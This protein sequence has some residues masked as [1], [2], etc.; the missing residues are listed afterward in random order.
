M[1]SF[2]TK[3]E[4]YIELRPL[5]EGLLCLII[6]IVGVLSGI[7]LFIWA[8]TP[9]FKSPL[10]GCSDYAVGTR[11]PESCQFLVLPLS[12]I[13]VGLPLVVIV[14]IAVGWKKVFSKVLNQTRRKE[15]RGR[16][17]LGLADALPPNLICERFGLPLS[18]IR[19]SKT[20]LARQG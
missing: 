15:R 2:R 5:I 11:P 12:V 4:G 20:L 13:A 1:S 7:G 10:S 18:Q 16:S 9:P 3:E 14:D 17:A 8:T 6:V 19:G